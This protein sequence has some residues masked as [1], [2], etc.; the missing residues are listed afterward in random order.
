MSERKETLRDRR[1]RETREQIAEVGL[2]LF[3]EDGYDETT[4][5]AVAAASGVAP[6]TLFH[7]FSAK[8]QILRH[9]LN[10]DFAEDLRPTLLA[11]PAEMPPV[12]AVRKTLLDLIARHDDER[13]RV[14]DRVLNSTAPLRASKQATFLEW[15]DELNSALLERYPDD[16]RDGRM[17]ALAMVSVGAVRLALERRRDEAAGGASLAKHLGDVF[18][19]LDELG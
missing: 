16:E 15:E 11:Q 6:R 1:R 5:D 2:R 13:L 19:A 18:R 17:R 3:D 10:S 12:E 4:M 14:V 7:Y 9:W 8:D